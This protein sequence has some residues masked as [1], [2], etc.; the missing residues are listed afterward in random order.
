VI[1]HDTPLIAQFD[2]G[3]DQSVIDWLL[4]FD[5]Y[6]RSRSYTHSDP[7]KEFSVQR[8][9]LSLFDWDH[10]F[11]DVQLKMLCRISEELGINHPQINCESLQ[12]TRYRVGQ[13]YR[14]HYDHFNLKGHE[15]TVDNDRV[16][17]ALLYLNDGFIGGETEF[18][19]LNISVAPRQGDILYFEYPSELADLTLHAGRPIQQGE[20]RIVSLWIRAQPW[21][22]QD[23]TPDL[24]AL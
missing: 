18:P 4:S 10:Q 19:L 6:V 20:K 23:S 12:L 16:A 13:E 3:L 15:Q 17:T 24:Q 9:S 8:N 7:N 5:D 1:L 14:D 21:I 11:N 2:S 22:A